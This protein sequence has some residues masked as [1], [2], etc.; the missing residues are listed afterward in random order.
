MLRRCRLNQQFATN[1]MNSVAY[2]LPL[3]K[4]FAWNKESGK[5]SLINY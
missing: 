1:V 3:V 5:Q 2:L 4:K